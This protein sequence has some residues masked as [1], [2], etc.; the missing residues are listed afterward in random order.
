M[1]IRPTILVL[2]LLPS[3]LLGQSNGTFS[4][5]P[6]ERSAFPRFRFDVGFGLGGLQNGYKRSID[7][8]Q[9]QDNTPHS[10]SSFTWPVLHV[11]GEY[12]LTT[13]TSIGLHYDFWQDERWY[14]ISNDMAVHHN[15]INTWMV[16]VRQYW[17]GHAHAVSIYSG[18]MIG[19]S[20]EHF[21]Q[22]KISGLPEKDVTRLAMQTTLIG[23]RFGRGAAA[24]MELGVGNKGLLAM[25]LSVAF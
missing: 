22:Y 1:P 24:S 17:N 8:S 15:T 5:A 6:P 11:E 9:V 7:P 13:E 2:L 4:N 14:K 12:A 16:S 25:G 18:L 19:P 20:F 10:P 23:F 3:G 21:H